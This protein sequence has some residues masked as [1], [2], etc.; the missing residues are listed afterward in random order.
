[1]LWR[2]ITK[3]GDIINLHVYADVLQGK[4]DDWPVLS[5]YPYTDEMVLEWDLHFLQLLAEWLQ[6]FRG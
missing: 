1:M 6:L 3:N 2:K 5:I 4:T